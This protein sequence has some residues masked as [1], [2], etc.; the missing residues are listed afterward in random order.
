MTWKS[1]IA[2][3]TAL[4][5]PFNPAAIPAAALGATAPDWLE[6]VLKFFGHEFPHRGATHYL[7]WP[8]A[9]IAASF[10]IDWHGLVFWFGVGYLSHWLADA[11]TI[12][13][14]PISPKDKHK[15]HLLG[16]KLRTGDTAE[17]VLSFGLLAASAMISGDVLTYLD[18]GHHFNKYHMDYDYLEEVGI[19]D[20]K[21]A[22]ETRFK[23]F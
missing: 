20:H 23:L 10:I 15:V 6:W 4:T 1:H 21:E 13:G 8:L 7:I 2:I 17:Y 11:L 12:A 14:V 3:A 9:I 16:G 18:G 19:I 22:V 5:L